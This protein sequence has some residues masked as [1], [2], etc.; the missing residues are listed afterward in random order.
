MTDTRTHRTIL[1]AFAWTAVFTA[2]HGYWALGGDFGFGDQ[3]AAFPDAGWLFSTVTAGM[4]AAGLAVPLALARG[5]G[6]R[7]LL[8]WLMWAG[9]AILTA[10]GAIGLVDDALRFTGLAE[11][12]L[13][14]LSNEQVLGTAH[15][16]AYTVW[17]T[18]GIDAFFAAGGLLFGWAARR[19][20]A[21]G[22]RAHRTPRLARPSI[23]WAGYAAFG[24]AAAYAIGVRGYQGLG[25]MVGLPGTFEDPAAVQRASLLAGAFILL[26]GVGALAFVRPWGLRLPRWLV[27][28]P[29]L[30]GSAYA[31]AHA[32]TAYITKP[33]HALGVIDLRFPG[34]ERLDEGA[35]MLWDLLFYEPWFLGLGI[36]VTLGALHHHRRTGGSRRAARRL[37]VAT[38]G[39]SVAL[40]VFGVVQ[41]I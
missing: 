7:R 6:P 34:W 3:E 39:A 10:R 24:W 14:G 32:L 21:A 30:A 19:A 20:H 29:A 13:S 33:L 15:P 26:V 2:W 22:P 35:L 25:G 37:V 28:I 11:T 16:S 40:T 41:V 38:A 9:A 23:A 1:Y 36:L 4:F 18:V 17:S 12:G 27:I 5:V 31:V 8:V